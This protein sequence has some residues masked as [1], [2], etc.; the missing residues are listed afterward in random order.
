MN[1]VLASTTIFSLRA[2]LP[3]VL[4]AP[5]EGAEDKYDSALLIGE[6]TR[7]SCLVRKFSAAGATLVVPTPPTE[8]AAYILELKNGQTI[9][10]TISWCEEGEVG[11]LFD[12]PMDVV[13]TLAR[14]LAIL[15]AERR[16][17]PRVEM[18][19]TVSIRRG[20][21]TEFTRARDVSTAGVGIET[22]L[23]L[24][25]DDPV[26]IAFD[27]LRPITGV[28]K[29]SSGRF[30]GVAF[31][32]ELGWQTL[33]PW[34][35]QVQ[36]RP[37]PSTR[38]RSVFE[39]ERGFGLAADKQAIRLDAP[40]RIREGVRWWNIQVRI[41]TPTLIEFDAP[42]TFAKGAQ[43]WLSLPGAAGWPTSVIEADHNRYLAEFRLPLRPHDLALVSQGRLIAS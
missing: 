25:I 15:P 43:L 18:S 35:R 3:T 8:G 17:V 34:L 29:W 2:D 11:F 40:G 23:E 4:P 26:E 41:L 24:E 30:A 21:D 9:F 1:E 13:G 10:G 22:D 20:S 6:S 28:V 19:Q 42:A 37:S 33:M 36:S 5:P 12:H 32:H 14:N 7:E 27:G 16:R 39:E 31:D 38:P